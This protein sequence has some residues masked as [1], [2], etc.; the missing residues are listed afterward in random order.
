MTTQ[1]LF[2]VAICTYARPTGLRKAIDSLLA[3][4]LP[5]HDFEILV[6]DN[7]PDPSV[8]ANVRASY[9]PS[10]ITWIHE[11][12]PGLSR[13]RNLVIC[14]ARGEIVAFMDDDAVARPDWLI[15]L[16]DAFNSFGPDAQ[17][18]GGR[19]EPIWASPRPPW[20]HD[21]L[22]GYLS[23]V[24][25]GGERRVLNSAE[26][27]AG[28]NMAFR[29]NAL[30]GTRGFL[31]EL[32]RCGPGHSLLSNEELEVLDGIR[33]HGGLVVYAPDACVEHM[34][35]V[36]RLTQSWLRKRVA[37][38]AISDYMFHADEAERNIAMHWNRL[39]DFRRTIGAVDTLSAL[40]ISIDD[41]DLFRKQTY[42]VYAQ[43][44]L[45]LTGF[46]EAAGQRQAIVA[47]ETTLKQERAEVSR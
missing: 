7:A 23:I 41:P 47:S 6:V 10:G 40:H 18:A 38:Q 4:T 45:L 28:T 27:I 29:A 3:Q 17:A 36:E 31:N 42:A 35:A 32:G 11:P 43:T 44:I 33:A 25:W 9:S 34:I 30:R 22:L 2:T 13:A 26:W 39:I 14:A 37:W 19:V 24:N 21:E 46:L 15:E 1:P 12:T 5:R 16:L 20:L 8:L